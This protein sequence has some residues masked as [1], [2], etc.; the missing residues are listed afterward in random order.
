MAVVSVCFG[1]ISKS[2]RGGAAKQ[3]ALMGDLIHK[4][5]EALNLSNCITLIAGV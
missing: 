1:G 3:W 2:L 4:A 5:A